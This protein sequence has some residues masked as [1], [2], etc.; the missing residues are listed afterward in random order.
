[1]RYLI[2]IFFFLVQRAAIAQVSEGK[3]ELVQIQDGQFEIYLPQYFV[4]SQSPPGVMHN[5]ARS[6]VYIIEVPAQHHA[7]VESGNFK[8]FLVDKRMRSVKMEH[9]KAGAHLHRRKEADI[10]FMEFEIEGIKFERLNT[11]VRNKNKLYLIM[12]HYPNSMKNQVSEEM[13]KIFSSIKFL[14]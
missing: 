13:E 10:E 4:I 11:F 2:L 12:A 8:E 14:K 1:M 9:E 7:K 6:M 3:G 5:I